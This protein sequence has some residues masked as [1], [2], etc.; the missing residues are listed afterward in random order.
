MGCQN[1]LY[2]LKNKFLVKK[3][4]LLFVKKFYLHKNIEGYFATFCIGPHFKLFL[5]LDKVES[6]YMTYN[7]PCCDIPKLILK[8]GMTESESH[9]IYLTSKL[10][11]IPKGSSLDASKNLKIIQATHFSVTNYSMFLPS[12]KR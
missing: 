7:Q 12:K 1:I 4:L 8:L 3:I 9:N 11:K 10:L 6:V 5:Y 2:C